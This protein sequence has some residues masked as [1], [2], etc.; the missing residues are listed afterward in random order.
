MNAALKPELLRSVSRSFS[1]SLLGLPKAQR[2]QVGLTYMLARFADTISDSGTWT[3]EQRQQLLDLWERILLQKKPQLW[4]S[5]VN[6]GGFKPNEAALILEGPHLLELFMQLNE[7]DQHLSQEL[8]KTLIAGMKW[9]LKTFPRKSELPIFGCADE[10]VFE[11]YCYSIAGCVGR[12]WVRSFELPENLEILAVEY[13][14]A[15]QRINILRDVEEDWARGR[16]YL[17]QSQLQKF[18]ISFDSCPWKSPHWKAFQSEFISETKKMLRFGANFCDSLS[19]KNRR[20]RFA[21]LMPLK[22]GLST[23]NLLE[24]R[25]AGEPQKIS[26]SQVRVHILKTFM[27][28][29]LSRKVSAKVK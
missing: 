2:L 13:G 27:D 14:K 18:G 21:S 22:I 9:D 23:L 7:R 3:T 8:L 25:K 29:L 1:L 17:P 4:S 12:Y 26:R 24:N 10:K 20:L 6:L 28:V 16:V 11:W 15:L 5:S 19:R